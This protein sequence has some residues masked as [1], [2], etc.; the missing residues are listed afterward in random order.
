MNLYM[1]LSFQETKIEH[2]NSSSRLQPLS[3]LGWKW[4][5]ISMDLVFTWSHGVSS[6]IVLI[7][8]L[9][10]TPRFW[11]SFPKALELRFRLTMN[12][13]LQLNN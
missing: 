1:L 4:D 12:H 11:E 13:N 5:R 9:S 3:I 10:L 6:S 8:S 2:L 7:E